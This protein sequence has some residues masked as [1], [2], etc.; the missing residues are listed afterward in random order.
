MA[1]YHPGPLV[2]ATLLRRYQ[3]FLADVRLPCGGQATAHC[4]NPGRMTASMPS[5]GAILLSDH[6]CGGRRKLRYTWELSRC[7]ETWVLVNTAQANRLVGLALRSGAIP[8]LG[9]YAS[10]RA[11]VPAGS[12]RLDFLLGDRCYLEV[13][14]VTLVRGA[15]ASF[16]D[17]PTAR[18]VRHLREL[19]QRV[20]DGAR[21]VIFFLVGRE[22][23]E[24]FR[25][26]EDVDPEYAREL[27][28]SVEEGVELLVYRAAVRPDW[29]GLERRLPYSLDGG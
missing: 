7:Q 27:K 19:Q 24:H 1:G 4:P 29:I 9:G 20:R 12:S 16:P 10:V 3:R 18:G 13:K 22:D 26:A 23:A 15:V 21:A 17:A 25:P 11:E 6:G 14:Q 2:E 28:M 8:E 5:E